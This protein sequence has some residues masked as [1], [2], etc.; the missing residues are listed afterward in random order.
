[1]KK[2]GILHPELSRAIASL[3]HMD[4]L[5]IA[6]AGLPIPDGPIRIDLALTESVPGFLETL[7]AVLGEMQVESAVIAEEMAQHSPT[8]RQESLKLLEGV[9]IEEIPHL[10][11][12]LRTKSARAVVRTGEFTP[13]ANVI[14]IAGVLF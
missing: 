10:Q 3:G 6:D 8:L 9:P 14:L 13:Y 11:F 5:V 7:R 12:K 4:I 2:D 1:M